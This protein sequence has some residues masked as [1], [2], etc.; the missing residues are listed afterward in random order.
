MIGHSGFAI[1]DAPEPLKDAQAGA[2]HEDS[3]FRPTCRSLELDENRMNPAVF[4]THP[5]ILKVR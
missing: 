4:S 3:R 1:N 2:L 5:D